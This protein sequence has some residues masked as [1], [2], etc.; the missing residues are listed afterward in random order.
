M[1]LIW[2][3]FF[4]WDL[5]IYQ[6]LPVFPVFRKHYPRAQFSG[7][8]IWFGS[9]SFKCFRYVNLVVYRGQP[10]VLLPSI[11]AERTVFDILDVCVTW[12]I[13][14]SCRSLII[15]FIGLI[16]PS[17][18]LTNSFVI[19]SSYTCD[20][21]IF[22][23]RR[24]LLWWN[25]FILVISASVGAHVLAPQSN[26]VSTHAMYMC[27][28]LLLILHCDSNSILTLPLFGWLSLFWSQYHIIF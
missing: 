19:F 9:M 2:G 17:Y 12:P 3:E 16:F 20:I 14:L 15:S 4:W 23:I 6:L 5:F 11:Y 18:D 8:F 7:I 21:F 28:S 24:I 10:R 1:F 25:M 13:K 27:V 22:R 26:M